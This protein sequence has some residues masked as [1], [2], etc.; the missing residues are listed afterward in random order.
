MMW[1]RIVLLGTLCLQFA[2]SNANSFDEPFHGFENTENT[3]KPPFISNTHDDKCGAGIYKEF[4][5]VVGYRSGSIHQ[6]HLNAAG[7]VSLGQPH[8][9]D[10]NADLN[11]LHS[12]GGP[13]PSY[14]QGA[15]NGKN[16][17]VANWRTQTLSSFS[18]NPNNGA[19]QIVDSVPA[20][21]SENEA[22]YVASM[23]FHPNS[24]YFYV[25]SRNTE[26]NPSRY[27]RAY[28]LHSSGHITEASAALPIEK[29]T[30]VQVDP[31]GKRLFVSYGWG[32][33]PEQKIQVYDILEEGK[34]LEL[35]H[36]IDLQF[37]GFSG[38]I[39]QMRFVKQQNESCDHTHWLV[40]LFQ[41]GNLASFSV[42]KSGYL[43]F[44]S[45]QETKFYPRHFTA[46]ESGTKIF[47]THPATQAD[48]FPSHVIQAY[49]LNTAGEL[50]T[51]TAINTG[52]V[53]SS[54]V[55]VVGNKLLM[56]SW[57][58]Y[59]YLNHGIMSGPDQIRT[60]SITNLDSIDLLSTYTFTNNSF[61]AGF[62]IFDP[63]PDPRQKPRLEFFTT[64]RVKS[65]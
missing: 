45:S 46:D 29:A 31:E 58:H 11:Y 24:K 15:P 2:C 53:N 3:G 20:R 43:E 25:I 32:D 47:L 16:L 8:I 27:L 9:T 13:G 6:V 61:P 57:T 54:G 41:G 62:P 35:S 28:Q 55:L 39:S 1:S 18:V 42:S 34:T 40:A 4:H 14:L 7:Q 26:H 60:Y 30:Y 10:N 64:V 38:S 44:I 52:D 49:E 63:N 5:Y 48:D 23:D 59:Q 22:T 36:I 12:V 56:G 21:N 50:V 37:L 19:L 65:E 33:T 51:S 17:I